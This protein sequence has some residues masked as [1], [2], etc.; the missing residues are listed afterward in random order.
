MCFSLIE[1]FRPVRFCLFFSSNFTIEAVSIKG[2]KNITSI[3]RARMLKVK[4]HCCQK[5]RLF[6]YSLISFLMEHCVV[7]NYCV[8]KAELLHCRKREMVFVSFAGLVRRNSREQILAVH[9]GT[10]QRY[11]RPSKLVQATRYSTTKTSY[12]GI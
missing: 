7:F 8:K 11:Q 9:V 3:C 10:R 5:K 12:K 2:L 6:S 1:M 4:F